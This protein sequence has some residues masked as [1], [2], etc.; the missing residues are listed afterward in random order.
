MSASKRD[1][2]V[3]PVQLFVVVLL[4]MLVPG[5]LGKAAE[6][7]KRAKPIQFIVPY[8]AGGGQRC[9][10]QVH[11]ERHSGSKSQPHAAYRG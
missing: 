1:C 3:R 8:A 6:Q 7:W 2:I 10:R 5:G 9:V 11:G 4:A